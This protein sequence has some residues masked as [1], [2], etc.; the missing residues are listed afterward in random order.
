MECSKCHKTK[1][2]SNYS[3]KNVKDNIYY[4]YC[5][6]CRNYVLPVKKKYKEKSKEDY[7]MR[8]HLNTI[9]CDC[10][11]SYVSFRDYHIYRHINSSR[12]KKLLGK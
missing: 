3:I 7:E 10:G 11:V 4:Q 9:N 2:I 6:D 5:N 8:K 12:H 1:D